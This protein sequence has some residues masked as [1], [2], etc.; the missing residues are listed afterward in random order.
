MFVGKARS[1]SKKDTLERG[2]TRVS[3]GLTRK[4]WTR[5]ESLALD[6]CCNLLLKV[7]KCSLKK[8]DNN[9]PRGKQLLLGLVL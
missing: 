4:Y 9:V 5:L 3:S 8:F 2:F 7:V 1:L 6:K